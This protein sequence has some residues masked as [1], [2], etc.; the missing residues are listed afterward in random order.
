VAQEEREEMEIPVSG[1][2]RIDLEVRRREPVA[3]GEEASPP[4]E[5]GAE[6]AAKAQ[7][8]ASSNRKGKS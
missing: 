6:T 7:A 2:V 8:S 3:R 1:L 4:S 5:E